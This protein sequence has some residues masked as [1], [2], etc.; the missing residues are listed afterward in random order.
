[1]VPKGI[2]TGRPP[3]LGTP[4]SAVWQSPQFPARNRSRPRS[5]I[6]GAWLVIAVTGGIARWIGRDTAPKVS[7]PASASP[8]PASAFRQPA[9]RG[10]ATSACTEYPASARAARMR[11]GVKGGA[12]IRTP[13]ASKTAFA[14]AAAAGTAA[15]SPTPSGGSPGRST[16][17]VSTSG[18]SGNRRIGSPTSLSAWA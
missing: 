2:S 18:T 15:L 13:V 10:G 5:T 9:C 1:M 17:S 7:A 14:M 11:S 12:R 8:A 6:S 3:A 4:S 16:S